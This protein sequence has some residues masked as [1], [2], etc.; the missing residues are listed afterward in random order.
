MAIA[1]PQG[2][3]ENTESPKAKNITDIAAM[4][5]PVITARGLSFS[6]GRIIPKVVVSGIVPIQ[7]I[8]LIS[9]VVLSPPMAQ[10]PIK[11]TSTNGIDML[12]KDKQRKR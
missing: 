10:N 8:T 6:E 7:P 2:G 5:I 9:P 1:H 3:R 11:K 4:A 12:N